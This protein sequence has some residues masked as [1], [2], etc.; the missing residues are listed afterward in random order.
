M[1]R[2]LRVRAFARCGLPAGAFATTCAFAIVIALKNKM[3]HIMQEEEEEGGKKKDKKKS[4]NGL[5]KEVYK[6]VKSIKSKKKPMKD[7]Q[8]FVKVV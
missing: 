6:Q 5:S 3:M 1:R 7:D 4:N 8:S 2:R